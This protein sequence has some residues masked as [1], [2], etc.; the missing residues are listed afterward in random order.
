M[1]RRRKKPH[2]VASQL[3]QIRVPE[4]VYNYWHSVKNLHK[5]T[6][7]MEEEPVWKTFYTAVKLLEVFINNGE[8]IRRICIQ[9]GSDYD[10]RDPKSFEKCI[11]KIR[12][13]MNVF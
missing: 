12:E 2:E 3:V 7:N 1:P 6:C 4:W 9:H 8:V 5:K 13:N 10:I 11:N